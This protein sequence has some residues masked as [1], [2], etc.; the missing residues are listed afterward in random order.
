LDRADRGAS[1][2]PITLFGTI[3]FV[4]LPRVTLLSFVALLALVAGSTLR[5]L[6]WITRQSKTDWWAEAKEKGT[7]FCFE[8]A[9][10]KDLFRDLC[11]REN[12]QFTQE[13]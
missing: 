1:V 5:T 6:W 3:A 13:S 12:V 8:A 11:D 10:A 2:A 7:A 9:S 4:A